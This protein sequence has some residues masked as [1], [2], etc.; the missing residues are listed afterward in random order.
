MESSFLPGGGRGFFYTVKGNAAEAAEREAD[1]IRWISS[2]E[3]ALRPIPLIKMPLKRQEKEADE[4]R[5]ISSWELA[6][7]PIPLIK[8]PLKRQE[9]R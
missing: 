3:L 8:M 1:E 9:K 5:W 4:I 6:L 7:Q 2:W